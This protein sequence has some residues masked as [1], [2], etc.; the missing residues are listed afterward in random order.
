MSD[1]RQPTRGNRRLR[2]LWRSVLATSIGLLLLLALGLWVDNAR[3]TDL[4]DPSVG[5]TSALLDEVP[6]E[7]PAVHFTDVAQSAGIQ[8]Q[9]GRGPRNRHLPEDTGSGLAW[10]DYDGDGDLDLY[11]VSYS[12][13]SQ[14]APTDDDGNRL[15]RNDTGDE[16]G[17]VR[18][19]DVTQ[20]AGVGDAIGFGMGASFVDFDSDGDVDLYV[21]NRGPNRLFRNLGNATFEEVAESLGVADPSWSIAANWGDLDRDGRLDLYV[22]NYLDFEIGGT[23]DSSEDENWQSVPFTLNPNSFDPQPNRL[24]HQLPTGQFEEIA[25]LV[26]T[27]NP[28]GRSLGATLVDL[29]GDH[30]L[31]LYVANDVSPNALFHNLGEEMDG[32]LFD[33]W[34]ARTG[35]ADPRGS[36]GISVAVLD[37]KADQPWSQSL[38]DLFITHWI[39]QENALYR[40]SGPSLEY[41]DKVRQLRLGEIST[42]RVGWG[43]G[44]LDF[45]LDG[46]LDL[47]VANGSTL[48]SGS[49]PKLEAQ[50]PFLFWNAGDRFFDLAQSAGIATS[51]PHVARGLATG[52]YDLDGDVDIALSINRSQPLLLRN[53]TER[54]AQKPL[55]VHLDRLPSLNRGA[56]LEVSLATGLQTRLV[57]ADSS[58]ASGHSP[59]A[60]FGIP[61]AQDYLDLRIT[62]SNGARQVFI[63][64]PSR[65]R[66]VVRGE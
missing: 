20:E 38:P 42:D 52:D 26:G 25:V 31:D 32:L 18:F 51:T 16:P 9:H 29:D 58:F 2:N 47:V 3:D 33:E 8:W 30:W 44:F 57:G 62:L 35:T 53:E 56:R 6:E 48:E 39:A 59:I 37:S 34:S 12:T 63:Q 4:Q 60:T 43:C 54:G 65:Q 27:S 66:I 46:R 1:R 7:P 13:T 15:F 40:P 10:G 17:D 23:A 55:A 28:E 11:F 21:T 5:V 64:L 49:P 45:D 61:A 14:E 19:V 24:F 41:H 36:M 22:T 50:L